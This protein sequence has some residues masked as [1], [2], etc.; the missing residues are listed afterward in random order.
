M[1]MEL[2]CYCYSSASASGENIVSKRKVCVSIGLNM[3]TGIDA[4][5][6]TNDKAMQILESRL[7]AYLLW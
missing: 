1:K 7:F 6:E 5:L 4:A 2:S 3:L